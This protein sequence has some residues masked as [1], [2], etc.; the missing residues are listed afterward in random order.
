MRIEATGPKTAQEVWRLYTCPP[1]WPTWAPQI[2]SVRGVSDPIS[3]GASGV[4][5]GPLLLRVPFVIEAVDEDLCTWTWRVGIGPLS[6]VLDHG[7]D[8]LES[9]SC[10]WADVHAPYVMVLAY[11][12][13]ARLAL[14]RLVGG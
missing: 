14:R 13:I 2:S 5:H 12:P 1:A 3:P 9:G 4:V 7:V 6:V 8:E 11:S 10:A